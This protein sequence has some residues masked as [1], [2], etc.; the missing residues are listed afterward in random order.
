L[1]ASLDRDRNVR[2]VLVRH[3]P[4]EERDPVRWPNDERRP[5]TSKGRAQTRRAA[6]GLARVSR[7]VDRMA[8]SAAERAVDTAKMVQSALD[9][10]PKLETWP[11]LAPGNLPQVILER[12]RRSVRP[13]QELML[14]GHEPTLAELVGLALVG[15]GVP[16]VHLT[17]GGAACLEFPRGVKPGAARLVWLL[18][19][20]QLADES[21]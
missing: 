13:G 14:V 5:L 8:S 17:K 18:T 1:A 3:G 11:E 21:A 2:I 15:D 10:P 9:D 12:L 19:R 4:A 6:K 7:P 16:V 20:K